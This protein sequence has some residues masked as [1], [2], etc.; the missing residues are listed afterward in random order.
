M[1]V[2]SR[3][4]GFGKNPQICPVFCENVFSRQLAANRGEPP[5]L[6]ANRGLN[7]IQSNT[8]Q[9]NTAH[10]LHKILHEHSSQKRNDEQGAFF[11]VR[12]HSPAIAICDSSTIFFPYAC[13]APFQDFIRASSGRKQPDQI[14]PVLAVSSGRPPWNKTFLPLDCF[15][16]RDRNPKRKRSCFRLR[17]RRSVFY[18]EQ[19]ATFFGFIGTQKETFRQ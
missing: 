11:C 4:C 3:V 2:L 7:T 12:L 5:Q 14:S 8:I 9:S 13:A 17:E 16:K 6:A 15:E 1:I 10:Q 18:I 19:T